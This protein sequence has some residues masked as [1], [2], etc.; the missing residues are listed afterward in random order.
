MA[1]RYEDALRILEGQSSD[2]YTIY[3]WIHRAVSN[4][5]I[6]RPDEAKIWVARTLEKHPDL[7]IEGYLNRP[8]WTDSDRKHLTK[9]MQAAGF[10]ACARPDQLKG[11]EHP[12]RL[13]ECG[14][15][16]APYTNLRSG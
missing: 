6:N 10:P 2:N 11:I 5:M 1:E 7:T 4:A 12:I 8:D 3:S 15:S 14:T 16:V 13:P 9:I